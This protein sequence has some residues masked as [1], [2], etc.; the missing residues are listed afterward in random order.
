[1]GSGPSPGWGLR[2]RWPDEAKAAFRAAGELRYRSE[3]SAELFRERLCVLRRP[4]ELA[5]ESSARR[6]PQEPFRG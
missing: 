6:L 1:M 5:P 4:E 2:A 3:S